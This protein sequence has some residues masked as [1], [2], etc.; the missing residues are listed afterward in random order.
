MSKN[1]SQRATVCV[2]FRILTALL[3]ATAVGGT[4]LTSV[5]PVASAEDI[6]SSPKPRI[7]L[8]SVGKSDAATQVRMTEAYGKLPLSFEANQGQTDARVNFL[9]RGSGYTLFLTA[10]EAV[11]ALRE[12]AAPSSGEARDTQ[13]TTG[14]VL[15]MQLIGANP[16]PAVAGLERLPG[17]VNYFIGHDPAKWRSNVPLYGKVEYEDVYPGIDLVYYGNQ[18]QLEY[19]FV[20]RPAPARTQSGSSPG[21]RAADVDAAATWCCTHRAG[22]FAQRRPVIYQEIGGDRQA[23]AGALRAAGD[24]EVGFEVGAYDTEPSRWSSTRAELL[25]LPGRQRLGLVAMAS[26]WTP[27]ATPT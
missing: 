21:G 3:L 5:S 8:F 1:K 19:D 10:T 14:T 13:V 22:T 20:V 24:A 2:S 6:A 23:V 27:R 17:Q 4:F 7:P 25:D 18:G 12:S 26:P 15:R 16:A 11:L 9:S